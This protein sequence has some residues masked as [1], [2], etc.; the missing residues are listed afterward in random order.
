MDELT[1]KPSAGTQAHAS[2]IDAVYRNDP[3][4]QPSA[5]ANALG[6]AAK[7]ATKEEQP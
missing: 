2:E 3:Q 7:L 1:N 4:A 5:F 6:A